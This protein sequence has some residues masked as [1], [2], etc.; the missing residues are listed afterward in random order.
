[1]VNLEYIKANGIYYSIGSYELNFNV[2]SQSN[3][4][5]KKLCFG[6]W[7]IEYCDQFIRPNYDTINTRIILYPSG[8]EEIKYTINKQHGNE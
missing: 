6:R 3:C 8:I 1:M 4:T 7:Q 5:I 2:I